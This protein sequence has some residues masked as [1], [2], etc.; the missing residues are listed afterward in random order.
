MGPNFFPVRAQAQGSLC[1]ALR[2]LGTRRWANSRG[3]LIHRVFGTFENWVTWIFRWKWCSLSKKLHFSTLF[4]SRKFAKKCQKMHTASCENAI[5]QWTI[6]NWLWKQR[7]RSKHC[8]F[9]INFWV[10][11]VMK[12]CKKSQQKW[13]RLWK[14]SYNPRW[15]QNAIFHEK[16]MLGMMEISFY[17]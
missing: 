9:F 15:A 10:W 5:L 7:F 17:T 13:S 12:S 11:K 3:G 8:Y 4:Q 14:L 2:G 16:W 1:P 6:E